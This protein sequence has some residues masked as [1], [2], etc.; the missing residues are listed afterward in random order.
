MN[1]GLDSEAVLARFNR[2]ISDL[3]SGEVTRNTFQPWEVELLI[4]LGQCGLEGCS[5]RSTL[6]RY[7]R[8]VRRRLENGEPVP[9]KLSKYL[10]EI[11]PGTQPVG[12]ASIE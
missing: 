9:I 3:L 4:D 7:Q 1:R 11:R 10:G 8:A 6:L 12:A 2:L 5:R